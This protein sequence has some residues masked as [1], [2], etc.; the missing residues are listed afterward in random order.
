MKKLLPIIAILITCQSCTQHNGNLKNNNLKKYAITVYQDKFDR[1]SNK[2]KPNNIVASI[3]ADNDTVAYLTALKRFYIQKITERKNFN[4]GQ[5]KSFLIVDKNGI[6]L[7]VKL[8]DKIVSGLRNQVENIPNV[9]K[10][11]DDYK[12]DSL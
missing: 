9:K 11:I 4:Y 5:P 8:S 12:R 2:F 10:M 6:D 1:S 7:T 3:G